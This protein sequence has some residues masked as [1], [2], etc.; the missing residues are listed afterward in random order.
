MVITKSFARIHWQN[1]VNFGAVPVALENED[2]YDRLAQGDVLRITGLRQ[3]VA[4]LDYITI[5]NVTQGG[6]VRGFHHLSPRQREVLRLGGLIN[7]VKQAP[8]P[9][10]A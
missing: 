4:E 3:Q 6:T 8:R 5:E 2:D 1:L 9:V 10:P 7:W